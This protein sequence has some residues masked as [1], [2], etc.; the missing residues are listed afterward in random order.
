KVNKRLDKFTPSKQGFTLVELLVVIGIIAVLI[1]ILLPALGRARAA[2]RS[3]ACMANL[4]SIGQAIYMYTAANRGSLP[5]GYFNGIDPGD[6]PPPNGSYNPD[7]AIKWPAMLMHTLNSRYDLTFSGSAGSGADNAKLK[8]LFSCPDVPTLTESTNNSLGNGL[9]HYMCHPLLM[10]SCGD[11]LRYDFGGVGFSHPLFRVSPYRVNQVKRATEIILIFD[12]SLEINTATGNY[13]PAFDT[14]IADLIDHG[15]FH[16]FFGNSS[17]LFDKNY[18]ST[19]HADDSI[20]LTCQDGTV[21]G[22]SVNKDLNTNQSNIRFRHMKDTSANAL[23]VDGHVESFK[24][25]STLP[26]NDP[27]VT[28]LKR[29]NLYVNFISFRPYP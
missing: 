27:K 15:A 12:G 10:P 22:P 1:G 25:S 4:R 21:N 13:G 7:K 16:A 2:A 5:Y 6:P 8:E 24:Y 14:P 23:M 9:S 11:N 18:T 3:V 26:S 29:R 17:Y 28:N 20:N 19:I